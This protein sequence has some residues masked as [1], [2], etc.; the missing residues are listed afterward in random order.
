[1]IKFTGASVL[2]LNRTSEF[3]GERTA[4]RRNV[5]SV[6][7]EGYILH[8]GVGESSAY[9]LFDDL[10]GVSGVVSGVVNN[11]VKNISATNSVT[12]HIIIN[13]LDFG[14]GKI[15]SI[16]FPNSYDAKESHIFAGKYNVSF[17]FYKDGDTTATNEAFD[18]V[19]IP[20]QHLLEDFSEDFSASLDENDTYSLDHNISIKYLSGVGTAG[21]VID[22]VEQAKTLASNIYNQTLTTFNLL[23]P[24][25][26]GDYN[27]NGKR[28][29][30]ET[31]N[32]INGDCSFSQNYKLFQSGTA[33]GP[34]SAEIGHSFELDEGG[35]I[36]VNENVSI[37]GRAP[38][39]NTMLTNARAGINTEL[40]LSYTRCNEVYDAYK[41]KLVDGTY[42]GSLNNIKINL[43]QEF[44]NNEGSA[45]YSVTYTDNRGYESVSKLVERSSDFSVDD[46]IISVSEQGNVTLVNK[47]G[48]LS[49]ADYIAQ[50][51]SRATVKARCQDIYTINGGAGTLTNQ[52][53][54]FDLNG[55]NDNS[56]T[57][58]GKTISYNYS[59]SDDPE[60]SD[61]GL[62][63]KKQVKSD[64]TM[65]ILNKNN[66][67]IPNVGER[68]QQVD[69]SSL[70]ERSVNAVSMI[71][72][73]NVTDAFTSP[74][75]YQTTILSARASLLNEVIAEALSVFNNNPNLKPL[76]KSEIFVDSLT[77]SF[78]NSREFNMSAVV[79]FPVVRVSTDTKLIL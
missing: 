15:V 26:Y 76:D 4:R 12:D 48:T 9:R 14:T 51:P 70:G 78:N 59:F 45:N 42:G 10:D 47:K 67:M 22:P 18:S 3:F 24:D 23:V 40:G 21:T 79:K 20:H 58:M 19:T 6:S 29:F 77:Y 64:D 54:S 61:T 36:T 69:Q 41:S 33:S 56:D 75:Q 72:R 43:S 68:I 50:I 38:D 34:Y 27:T 25:H 55:I 57:K 31:Y 8:S 62:F 5:E 60:V 49:I 52:A 63:A 35:I 16:D 73:S 32:L 71:R 17:E 46:N 7:I 37:V 28:T 30:N 53:T 13:G 2:S 39:R 1:M 74:F 44:N 65:P 66:L 11:Y